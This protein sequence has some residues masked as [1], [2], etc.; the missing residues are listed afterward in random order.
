MNDSSAAIPQHVAIVMDGNGRWAKQRHLPRL[1]GHSAGVESARLA[2]E[3]ARE[4]GI[5]ALSLFAFST[6]NWQRPNEEVS[7][8]MSLLLNN[9]QK[10]EI[11]R[12]QE[13][14]IRLRIIG[15]LS[16]LNQKIQ[17]NIEAAQSLTAEN[18]EMDLVVAINYGGQWDIARAACR[19]AEEVASG[20][21][22]A[23]EISNSAFSKH[24]CLNDLPPV[25]L[26]IRTS[27]ELRISNFFLWQ[28]AYAE[29]YFTKVLWPDF[30]R[31]QFMKAL[32]HFAERQRRFGG[33]E[34][35]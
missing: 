13:H 6:E 27:G 20:Q 33:A 19:L 11:Q 9:L 10:K 22:A 1:A 21:L 35:C 8:L 26:F 32:S 24:L 2:I 30:D 12:L 16:Q 28:L 25:D 14:G 3:C 15:D 23:T 29:L 17:D 5:K 4:Q 7:H 18:R 34:T 31:E